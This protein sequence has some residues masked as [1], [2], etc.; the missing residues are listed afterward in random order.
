[1]CLAVARSRDRE[2]AAVAV[3]VGV[4]RGILKPNK[5][6]YLIQNDVT[7][8]IITTQAFHIVS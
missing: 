1:M 6:Y 7:I 2:W 4:P 5:S 8:T 3:G